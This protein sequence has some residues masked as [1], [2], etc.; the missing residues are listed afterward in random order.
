MNV[1]SFI[2]NTLASAAGYALFALA[3][4]LAYRSSR[5]LLFCVGEIGILAAYVLLQVWTSTTTR[6]GP[7]AW[8]L[9]LALG[10]A[11]A[12]LASAVAGLLLF[13]VLARLP[14]QASPFVGTAVTIAFSIALNGVLTIAWQGEIARL[15]IADATIS[16]ETW[17]PA[18]ATASVLSL[19]V[20]VVASL[21]CAVLLALFYRSRHGLELQAL[22]NNRTLAQ[23]RGI[24][25]RRRLA[26]VW[27][28]CAVI[29]GWAG[30]LCA[31]LAAVSTEGATVGFSGI[32]AAIVG[33][34]TSPGG[35][36]IGALLLAAGENATSMF[37]DA[38]YSAIVPVLLLVALLA[39]RPS[40]LSARVEAIFRT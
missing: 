34:L 31:S 6:L 2:A 40:G 32:V 14:D 33:G 4:V 7:D 17:L 5:V 22:A 21:L 18:P 15:P 13:V 28:C 25:V 12:T 20:V 9:G 36:L 39:L 1:V 8:P 3:V 38:R 26:G 10:L 37:F 30:I 35:A 24:P 11:A 27:V 29:S 23:L 16:L 19:G